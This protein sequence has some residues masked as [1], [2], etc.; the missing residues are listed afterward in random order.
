MFHIFKEI[1][2]ADKLVAKGYAKVVAPQ[3]PN[4]LP[5]GEEDDWN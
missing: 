1:I 2:I 4:L 5:A 3:I